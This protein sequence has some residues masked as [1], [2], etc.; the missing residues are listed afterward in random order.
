MGISKF[1]R[2]FAAATRSIIFLHLRFLRSLLKIRV[3]SCSFVVSVF[4][5][6]FPA[7][8]PSVLGILTLLSCLQLTALA[9]KQADSKPQPLDPV[10]AEREGKQFVVQLVSQRPAATFTNATLIIR[11]ADRK[12]H[13]VPIRFQ[14]SASPTNWTSIYRSSGP[15]TTLRIVHADRSSNAYFL[16]SGT[17]AE[18]QISPAE[19]MSPFAGSDFWPADLGLEFLHWPK[20]QLIRKEMYSSR[21]CNVLE[22]ST[23][24]E[25]ATGYSRVRAWFTAEPPHDLVRAE[26][27]DRNKKRIKVFDVSSIEKVEGQ[28]RVESVEMRD[29]LRDS[30]TIMEFK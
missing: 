8:C 27:Y 26:G 10:T 5:L 28:F 7:L 6:R 30:R 20:Q 14:T 15:N 23:S 1:V 25:P 24:E 17:N 12:E 18:Q 2:A 29:L 19:I 3:H 9:Q 13:R 22:S 4:R 11:D 16:S 21:F